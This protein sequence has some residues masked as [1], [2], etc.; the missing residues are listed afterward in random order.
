[1]SRPLVVMD[2][3]PNAHDDVPAAIFWMA[4]AVDGIQDIGEVRYCLEQ[5]IKHVDAIAA[6]YPV[7][8]PALPLPSDEGS[9]YLILQAIADIASFGLGKPEDECA[10]LPLVADALEL[11][12]DRVQLELDA[13]ATR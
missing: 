8:A 6:R 2:W 12:K 11:V 3:G 9:L 4:S 7:A 13:V 1:M 10:L 5:A